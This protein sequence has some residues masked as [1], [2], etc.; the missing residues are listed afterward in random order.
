MHACFSTA[1]RLLASVG[2]VDGPEK[3]DC[4]CPG[5]SAFLNTR[6]ALAAVWTRRHQSGIF[7]QLPQAL[8]EAHF[9]LGGRSGGAR[10]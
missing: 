6:I 2:V 8:F 4:R 1:P 9:V 3:L 7:S 10:R 5:L